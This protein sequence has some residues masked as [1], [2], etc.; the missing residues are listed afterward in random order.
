M[1]SRIAKHSRAVSQRRKTEVVVPFRVR[2]QIV[3]SNRECQIGDIDGGGDGGGGGRRGHSL[4]GP[5]SPG[6]FALQEWSMKTR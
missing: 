2:I 1:V 3:A 4:H 6:W 5:W